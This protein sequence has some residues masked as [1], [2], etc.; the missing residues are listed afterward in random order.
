MMLNTHTY[1]TT[2][3]HFAALLLLA[4]AAHRLTL[5]LLHSDPPTRHLLH[6]WTVRLIFVSAHP[7]TA[8]C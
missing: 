7:Q 3:L 4:K 2:E 8:H 5:L 1:C 6:L